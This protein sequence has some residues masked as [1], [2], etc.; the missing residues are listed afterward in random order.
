MAGIRYEQEFRDEAVRQVVEGGHRVSDVAE[1][2][3]VTRHTLYRWVRAARPARM[4][5][6]R[7]ATD[8]HDA[9]EEIKRLE[10]ELRR[11]REERDILKKAAAY[12]AKDPD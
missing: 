11:T 10:R 8:L 4:A 5:R 2:L 9:Q 6:P 7:Q 12:F 1:R 3:G